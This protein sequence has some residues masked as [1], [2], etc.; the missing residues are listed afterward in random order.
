ME[1]YIQKALSHHHI[2]PSTSPVGAGF[3]FV[4]K[5]DKTLRPCIDY[6]NLT[7]EIENM[8]GSVDVGAR[9]SDCL[10]WGSSQDHQPTETAVFLAFFGEGR[11]RIRG[12]LLSLCSFQELY[13]APPGHLLPLSTPSRPW[14]HIAVDFVTGLPP[15]QGHTVILTVIDRFSKA[16]HFIPLAQ[17]PS[18]S[19]TADIKV[20]HVF[21]YHGIP[22][23]IVSDR[24]PQ[25][26]S[27]VWRSFCSALGATV[28]L[29]SGYHPQSNGQAERS[30]QE[31]EAALRCL[32]AQNESDWSKYL[33]WV[34]YAHNTHSSTATGMSPFE[35]SLG[36]SPPLFPSQEL[37]LAVP[38]VQLHLRRCQDVWRQARAA[39]LPTRESNCQ[40]AN[41]RR[42]LPAGSTYL[43][44]IPAFLRRSRTFLRRQFVVPLTGS[45]SRVFHRVAAH[46]PHSPS[47][48]RIQRNP[49]AQASSA[50]TLQSAVTPHQE[51]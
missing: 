16:V 30:N 34:E 48:L 21:R 12:C 5:K 25:F 10:S 7:W 45:S 51:H 49:H 24:G 2:R 39:L 15:S 38:S 42:V 37:D 17:L 32:V 46:Q 36:F 41:R 35:A 14:S 26:T 22:C 9:F 4:E 3:F 1:T 19:D 33:I 27:Q 23:D 28:S 6:R 40:I 13:F 20:N 44:I 8:I 18:A 43:V 47:S 11:P 50:S 31:L 29:S